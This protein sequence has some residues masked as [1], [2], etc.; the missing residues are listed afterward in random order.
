M[1]KILLLTLPLFVAVSNGN[2]LMISF[3]PHYSYNYLYQDD[4]DPRGEWGFG[5]ELEIRN[6][7]PHLGLK[8]R[9]N[10]VI[11]PA[12]A[13]TN[14]YEYEFIPL[15]LCTS[16]DLLPFIE[17]PWFS[18][19]LETG[20]GLYLWRTLD[21]GSVVVLPDNTEMSERDIGFVGGFTLQLRPVRYIA[22][23]YATRYNYIASAELEKYGY[24]DKDEKI[25]EHGVGLKIFL[26]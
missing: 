19:T 15:T 14:A 22:L 16:F 4:L 17:S 12:V 23:E 18:F 20:F 7:I 24:F 9:G 26:P 8:L 3:S 13:G 25:W 6:F 5:G 2:G 11:Y 21:N 1:Q 10:R